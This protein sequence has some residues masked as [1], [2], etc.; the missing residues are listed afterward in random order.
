MKNEPCLISNISKRG[1]KY[2]RFMSCEIAD[3]N[4][5]AHFNEDFLHIHEAD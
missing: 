3:E 1:P 2:K 5:N 4:L